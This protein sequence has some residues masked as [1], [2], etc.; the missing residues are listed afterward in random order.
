MTELLL[1]LSVFIEVMRLSGSV[2]DECSF[3]WRPQRGIIKD[4]EALSK[5]RLG[6]LL[7][8][9]LE[10]PQISVPP[11]LVGLTLVLV[12]LALVTLTPLLDVEVRV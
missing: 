2:S 1:K 3:R 5:T 6:L 12:R 4:W 10:V 11:H 9:P 8:T 7:F